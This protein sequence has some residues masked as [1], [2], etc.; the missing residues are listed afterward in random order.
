MPARRQPNA[1]PTTSEDAAPPV[2]EAASTRGGEAPADS[3]VPDSAAQDDDM[4]SKNSEQHSREFVLKTASDRRVRF[5]RLW[6]TDI[7]GMLKSTAIT[8]DELEAAL[9]EGITFDGSVIEG[10][11]REDE[12]DLIAKPDANTFALLPFRPSANEGGAVA[13]LF[14]DILEPDGKPASTDPRYVLKRQR[15]AAADMGFTFYVGPEVEFFYFRGAGEDGVQQP[16][17]L[18][19]GGYFDLTPLDVSSG[20]RRQTALTLEEMGVGVESCHHEGA[21]SQHE[22]DLRYT[23]ALTMADNLMTFS[24]GRER[25][26]ARS[27]L[28]RDVH[29]E[30]VFQPERFGNA[31][32]HEPVSRHQKRLPR[33]KRRR[34]S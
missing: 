26:R 22:I 2:E 27:R 6:F 3:A 11:A 13:R 10:F 9:E 32:Q 17:T 30:T 25:S 24:P 28:L 18:D 29:A 4:K 34:S 5:V 21:P 16:L 8:A 31:H 20:M 33:R 19:S 1:K 12:S 14:C 15:R 23:D 7:L